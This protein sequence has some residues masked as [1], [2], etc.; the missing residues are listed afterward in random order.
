M[1]PTTQHNA[2]ATFRDALAQTVRAT[3]TT[4]TA[5]VNQVPV[6]GLAATASAS[7]ALASK[8]GVFM[9]VVL[10]IVSLLLLTACMAPSNQSLEVVRDFAKIGSECTDDTE[11]DMGNG[12]YCIQ[13]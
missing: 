11:C 1:T 12:Q 4:L 7:I 8:A 3:A 2:A 6:Q 13:T 9:R 10:Q 5:K